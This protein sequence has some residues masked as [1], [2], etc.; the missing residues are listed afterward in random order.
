MRKVQ[1]PSSVRCSLEQCALMRTRHVIVYTE[2]CETQYDVGT[3]IKLHNL[4]NFPETVN[5][6][7]AVMWLHSWYVVNTSAT[8]KLSI[9][10]GYGMCV[11]SF[12]DLRPIPS[13]SERTAL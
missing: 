5:R 8:K 6:P 12:R 11:M 13:N 10:N 2:A 7:V 3:K 1:M 9:A 4:C